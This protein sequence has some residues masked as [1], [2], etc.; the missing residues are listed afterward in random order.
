MTFA[1]NQRRPPYFHFGLS[2]FR[3][4]KLKAN[5]LPLNRQRNLNRSNLSALF[6]LLFPFPSL[7]LSFSLEGSNVPFSFERSKLVEM[8]T[9]KRAS[10]GFN[11]PKGRSSVQR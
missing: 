5:L 6:L 3:S 10:C 7:S 8:K 2:R 11:L 9:S 1:S 4:S